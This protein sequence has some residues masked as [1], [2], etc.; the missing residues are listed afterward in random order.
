M[1]WC[2]YIVTVDGARGVHDAIRSNS[3]DLVLENVKNSVTKAVFASITFS[4][5]NADFIDTFVKE[6]SATRL[7]RG[8]SFNLL[9][10]WPEVVEKHGLSI[11]EKKQLLLKIWQL[12]KDGYP[13]TLSY[14][15]FKALKNNDWKR[16]ISQIELG[17]RDRIFR[18]CRDVENPSIC[19][20]CG[21]AG[22]IEISQVLAL[23]PSALWQMFR[24]AIA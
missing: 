10:H 20:N 5:A 17:T 13:I 19:K 24:I 18:C 15:A 1:K 8:I 22:C 23:K 4:K 6:I 3:Y 7:F 11:E 14:A 16:P 9:T 21:Y 12:K 2:K